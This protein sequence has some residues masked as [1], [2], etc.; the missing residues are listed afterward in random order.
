[1]ATIT[2]TNGDASDD[3]D[4][5]YALSLGDIFLGAHDDYSDR[6]WIQV[7]LSADTIYNFTLRAETE[8]IRFKLVDSE[9]GLHL[10]S[11]FSSTGSTLIY[12][13]SVSGSYY[14]VIFSF[15]NDSDYPL[16]YEIELTEN[17]IPI[18][19]YDDLADYMTDGFWEWSGGSRAAFDVGPGE[20]LTA[21]ITSLTEAGQ[22]LAR[23]ALE[24]WSYVTGIEF[25]IVD[26]VN[27]DITFDDEDGLILAGVFR[28]VTGSS[29]PDMSIFPSL[30]SIILEPRLVVAHSMSTS[31]RLAMLSVLVIPDPTPEVISPTVLTT[32]S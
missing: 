12:P 18:G 32:Y 26:N 17:T 22:Q 16:D 3:F 30:S 4:T 23:W 13:P 15:G 24:A 27:A 28:Q 1:M 20:A 10:H 19:T 5:Q 7:E 2:E 25:Q 9:G 31:M 6:D 14:I 8:S 29:I 11:D 21:D